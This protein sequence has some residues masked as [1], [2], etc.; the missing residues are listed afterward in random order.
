MM[1]HC[2]LIAFD[3]SCFVQQMPHC[4]ATGPAYK[5]QTKRYGYSF[6]LIGQERVRKQLMICWDIRYSDG[7]EEKV[8]TL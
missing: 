8:F 2:H 7:L 1:G 4:C 3:N 6:L 5:V